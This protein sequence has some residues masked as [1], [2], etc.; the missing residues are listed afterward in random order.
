MIGGV[1][2]HLSSILLKIELALISLN[3]ALISIKNVNL[4]RIPKCI[5]LQIYSTI[6]PGVLTS[7]SKFGNNQAKKYRMGSNV[8]ALTAIAA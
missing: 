5:F 7:I 1:L 2:T 6:N 3:I 4:I 8:A